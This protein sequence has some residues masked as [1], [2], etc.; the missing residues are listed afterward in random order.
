MTTNEVRT[1]WGAGGVALMFLAGALAG[2]AA[3]LLMAPKSGAETRERIGD[4]IGQTGDQVRRARMA[5]RAAASAA[6]EAF[7]EAMRADH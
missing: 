5:A 7:S 2:A 6:R 3:S 1:G 4:A